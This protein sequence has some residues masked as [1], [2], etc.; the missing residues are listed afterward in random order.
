MCV[1]FRSKGLVPFWYK[2]DVL[3]F[4]YVLPHRVPIHLIFRWF[5]SVIRVITVA[6]TKQ[7]A[8]GERL[9]RPEYG[10]FF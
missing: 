1:S 6:N 5:K 4:S 7:L 2:G 9:I 10:R 8:I 3:T